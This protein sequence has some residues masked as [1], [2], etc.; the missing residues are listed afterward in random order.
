MKEKKDKS[1]GKSF[2]EGLKSLKLSHFI[3]LILLLLMVVCVSLVGTVIL[4][5]TTDMPSLENQDITDYDVTSYIVDKDGAFVE[6]MLANANYVSVEYDE[7]SDNMVNAITSIED[8]RFFKHHGVDPIRIT[9]AVVANLRAGGTVQ[10][11]STITQQLAGLAMLD[12]SEKTYKRKIQEAILAIRIENKYEKEEILNAYLNRCYFGPG[13]SGMSCYGIEAA[14][15]DILG[16]HASE[17][18]IPDAALLAGMVQNPS[19]W[20]PIVNPEQALERRE[21]VLRAMADNN[22]ITEDEFQKYNSEPI[23]TAT[24]TEADEHVKQSFN[25]SYIDTVVEEA[26]E[27]LGITDPQVLNSGGYII[28]TALDQDLQEYMY[29]YFNNDYYFPGGAGEGILQGAMVVMNTEDSSIAGMIGERHPDEEGA[30]NFNRAT[31]A[32]RQPGSTF[33]PIFVYGPAIEGGMGTGNTFLDA[34]YQTYGGHTI[35]NADLKYHGEVTIRYALEQS[36]NTVAARCIE[37]IGPEKGLEFAEKCGITSLVSESEDGVTDATISAALGGLTHG[38]S[39]LEMAGAY[40]AFANKGIYTK[41]HTITKITTEEGD[42][43]WEEEPES[44]R[45]MEET[46]AYMITDCLRS[47]ITD[48]IGTAATL[49]DGRP[50]AG[51]TGTTDYS[52]DLWFCGF[53]PQYVGAVWLG[54]DEAAPIYATSDATAAIFANIMS[55]LHEGLDVMD[56]ERPDG[57]TEVTIDTKCGLLATMSTP[58]GFRSTELYKSGTEPTTYSDGNYFY[59][60]DTTKPDKNTSNDDKDQDQDKDKD[61]SS[62]NDNNNNPGTTPETGG[63]TTPGGGGTTPGGG[64]NPDTGGGTYPDTGGGGGGTVTPTP[65]PGAGENTNPIT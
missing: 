56:F 37:E 18:T 44:H 58:F 9:G 59:T 22:V 31:Q 61:E 1:F 16:K 62:N 43:I 51:K 26:M 50:V 4:A 65:V 48:G 10:G 12:R 53:T 57:I 15:N 63:G 2:K 6:K 7:I 60:N 36:L 33:K 55:H 25:Q 40:G 30:R 5:A 8:K 28:H 64:T 13:M 27:A 52:K 3:L 14:A 20:S 47:V 34:E 39:P 35:K 45:A 24:I 49:Y 23:E 17:L 41:P 42:I 21:V 54:Y 46:T 19:Q 11:G 38:V 32:T 29:D